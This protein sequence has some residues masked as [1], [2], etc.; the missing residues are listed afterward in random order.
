[1]PVFFDVH[2]TVHCDKFLII[3]PTRCTNFSKFFILKWNST[4]F[5]RFLFPSSGVFHCTHS[6]GICYTGLLT[7]CSRILLEAVSKPVWHM[8]LLCVQWKTPDDGQ[9]NHPKHVGFH[10]KI[11]NFEKSVHLVGSIIRNQCH[12]Y[13][14]LNIQHYF[15]CSNV[16]RFWIIQVGQ[17]N[18]PKF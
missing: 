12:S 1:M 18:L 8:P 4:C 9:R 7:A 6:S 13:V 15:N 5:G 14:S 17:N 11:K 16:H 3:E 10:S 2:V